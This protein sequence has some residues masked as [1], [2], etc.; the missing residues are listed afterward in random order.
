MSV[1]AGLS[2]NKASVARAF[3]VRPI[4]FPFLCLGKFFN[5]SIK[6]VAMEV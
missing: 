4:F 2:F 5:I 6:G 1:R 3:H